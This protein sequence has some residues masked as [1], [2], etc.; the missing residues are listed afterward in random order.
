MGN[1]YW[2]HFHLLSTLTEHN[3]HIIII[4]SLLRFSIVILITS[5]SVEHIRN[6]HRLVYLYYSLRTQNSR[7]MTFIKMHIAHTIVVGRECAQSLC[8]WQRY[9]HRLFVSHNP[10]QKPEAFA[11]Q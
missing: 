2:L 1:E 9:K 11:G 4:L 7:L 8:A 3:S 5:H 6:Y 10:V